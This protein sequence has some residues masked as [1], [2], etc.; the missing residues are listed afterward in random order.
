[1]SLNVQECKSKAS[2]KLFILLKIFKW[3]AISLI[4]A[5]LA[6]TS[7]AIF[8]FSL[9]WV[10]NFRESHTWI[11]VF[12]P[13][14]GFLIGGLY[15]YYGKN[16][17]AGN[18]LLID[19]INKPK[20]ILPFRMSW[21]IYITT[22][23][24]HLFGGSAGR[25][26]VAVQMGGVLA[27]QL[28]KPFNL[29]NDER[30]I[31]IMTGIS[32]GFASLFGTPLAGAVFALEILTI[33]KIRYDA[34]FPCFLSAILGYQIGLV[35]GIHHS[36]YIIPDIPEMSFR[37]LISSIIAGVIFGIVARLFA[38]ATREISH[39]AKKLIFYPP[40]RPVAGGILILICIWITGTTK[41][42]GLGIPTMQE[43]FNAS[44]NTWAFA[45]KFAFTTLTLGTGFKGGEV[46][47][48]F[49]IGATLGNTLS[50]I[51]SLPAPLLAGMGFAAVFAGAANVPLTAI[52]LA[53]E[54][55]GSHVGIYAGIACVVSY[56]FSGH[57]G[58]YQSQQVKSTKYMD[59]S[60]L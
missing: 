5:I 53:M 44:V 47:P 34:I 3:A 58:I 20:N 6:G 59:F 19:E 33:G 56:L 26:G 54:L 14:A 48:L 27:D 46:M 12:L 4:T 60:E 16:A 57:S 13:L 35:L 42:I 41:Y 45:Y 39:L 23:M 38:K 8:S 36:V 43:A 50:S 52:F 29:T 21:M 11:I 49:F 31:L 2:Q 9:E 24:T 15:F 7:S 30:R 28:S 22:I 55:F 1:M 51:L 37:G 18:N 17:E 25:E 10:T 40:L 32:A